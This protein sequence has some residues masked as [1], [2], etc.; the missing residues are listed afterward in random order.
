MVIAHPSRSVSAALANKAN[1]VILRTSDED[2]RRTST[3]NSFINS[4]EILITNPAP[5]PIT[6]SDIEAHR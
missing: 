2:V 5:L 4:N 3:S 6:P 1:G